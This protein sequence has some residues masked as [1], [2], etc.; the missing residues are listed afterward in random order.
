MKDW[1]TL[2]EIAKILLISKQAAYKKAQKSEWRRKSFE[3][4]GGKEYRYYL[5]NVFPKLKPVEQL[6]FVKYCGMSL[7]ALQNE[8]KPASK[9]DVKC[10]ISTYK[11]R[12]VTKKPV[13]E[14]KD[15]SQTEQDIAYNRRKIITA[16]EESGLNAQ[17]FVEVYQQDDFMPEVKER[18]GRWGY[19]KDWRRFY[20]TWLRPYS[21]CGLSGLAPQYKARGGAG[22]NLTEE[23]KNL[24]E[25]LYLDSSKLSVP[26]ILET[27]GKKLWCNGQ[28]INRAPLP[29]ADSTRR[30]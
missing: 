25:Y 6:D 21:Q 23:Q 5:P 4:K 9:A 18:L 15:C 20:E 30:P 24:L 7:E 11:G 16:Y 12:S 10:E 27:Y 28:R 3:G 2:L 22:A 13:K 8:L 26:I 17:Q 19:L 29:Q 14:W 1:L